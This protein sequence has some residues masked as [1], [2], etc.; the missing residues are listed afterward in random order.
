LAIATTGRRVAV[1]PA[2]LADPQ[3]EELAAAL[4]GP[5]NVYDLSG[6]RLAQ[7]VP[8]GTV[9]EV[10][11]SWPD[12]AVI[13][14]RSDGTTAIERY[15]AAHERLIAATSVPDATRDATDLSIGTGA[16]VFREGNTIYRWWNIGSS[17]SVL[18]RSHGKPVGLSIEGRRVA[19]AANGRIRALTVP[20]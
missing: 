15:D 17:P 10:A 6:H 13:V 3:G 14:T 2:V 9:S 20:R 7:V 16:I 19:W 18:W 5:V 1:V 11:L 4:N 8:Q 12:L